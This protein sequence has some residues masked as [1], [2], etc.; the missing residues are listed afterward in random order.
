MTDIKLDWEPFGKTYESRM[1]FNIPGYPFDHTHSKMII[2]RPS[3]CRATG[4]GT[5][6]VFKDEWTCYFYFE[7]KKDGYTCLASLTNEDFNIP[8]TMTAEEMMQ[9][10]GKL[11][12]QDI[13]N[14]ILASGWKP[15]AE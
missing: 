8:N 15:V 4:K 13:A 14:A 2:H 5:E 3:E 9:A 10:M 12:P 6:V 1:N 11:T 7:L